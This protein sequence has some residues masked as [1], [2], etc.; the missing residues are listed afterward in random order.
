MLAVEQGKGHT[1][2][3]GLTGF[4][5]PT[6]FALLYAGIRAQKRID[7]ASVTSWKEELKLMEKRTQ[8]P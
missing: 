5:D 8:L 2:E 3:R 6:C 7:K 1:P 4:P